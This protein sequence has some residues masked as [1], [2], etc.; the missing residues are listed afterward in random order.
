MPEKQVKTETSPSILSMVDIPN[1][2][3]QDF[4]F[5]LDGT[6]RVSQTTGR[7]VY[8]KHSISNTEVVNDPDTGLPRM[9]RLLKGV[10]TVWMDEQNVD[11]KFANGMAPDLIF[12]DGY[13]RVPATDKLTFAF[14]MMKECCLNNKNRRPGSKVRYKFL[15]PSKEEEARLKLEEKRKEAMEYAAKEKKDE[16]LYHASY[17]HIDMVSEAGGTLSEPGIRAAYMKFAYEYPDEFLASAGSE[18][19]KY[20]Y[21][22]NDLVSRGLIIIDM[23]SMSAV[24][25]TGKKIC[26]LPARSNP[27]EYL[28]QFALLPEGKEFK[29]RVLSFNK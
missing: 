14:L 2:K 8:P 29:A 24:W 25:D 26:V 3:G 17:L 12:V 6:F 1:T 23:A 22:I 10:K 11:E 28:S 4:I 5:K 16:M 27:T 21:V 13:L 15:E 9:M 7:T 20:S 19:L 18:E